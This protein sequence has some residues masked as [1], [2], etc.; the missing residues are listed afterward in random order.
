MYSTTRVK[1]RQ[2]GWGSEG[3][4]IDS[5]AR[6]S[7]EKGLREGG[8]P[9]SRCSDSVGG[10]PWK[11]TNSQSEAAITEVKK[12]RRTQKVSHYGPRTGGCGGAQTEGN[13]KKDF[14]TN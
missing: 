1:I 6:Y 5:A 9:E 7:I 2:E 13:K 8:I 14:V 3:K 11:R 10:E 4:K 12:P